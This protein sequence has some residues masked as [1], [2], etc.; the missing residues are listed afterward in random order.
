MEN[1]DIDDDVRL[2]ECGLVAVE[3]R[4]GKVGVRDEEEG[5][6]P[7]VKRKKSAGCVGD[8][9]LRVGGGSVMCFRNFNGIL[10]INICG[11]GGGGGFQA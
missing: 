8:A 5:W 1:T 9:E 4:R 2:A 11:G 3:V 10:G 7:M 6:T